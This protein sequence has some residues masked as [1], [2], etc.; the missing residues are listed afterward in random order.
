MPA[1]DRILPPPGPSVWIEASQ[2]PIWVQ[3]QISMESKNA[4]PEQ[5]TPGP[6]FTTLGGSSLQLPKQERME[7]KEAL[8]HNAQ[9]TLRD[10]CYLFG[11]WKG[12][13]HN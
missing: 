12:G 2:V 11:L 7:E 1:D 5:R 3:V 10:T 13:G 4:N 8:A 9:N 6:F